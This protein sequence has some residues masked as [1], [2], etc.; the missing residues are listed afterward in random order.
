[1]ERTLALR[2]TLLVISLFLIPT[3]C[4]SQDKHPEL[5]LLEQRETPVLTVQS[6]GAEGNE[7][8]FENGYVVK[9]GR[10]YHL[11][12]AEMVGRPFVVKMK[13][14][15][16]ASTDRL[17]WR[18]VS[19]LYSSSAEYTGQDPRAALWGPTPIYDEKEGRWN[20]FYT[21]Y[22]SAPDT[23]DM[24]R[25]NYDGKIWRAVSQERGLGGIDGPYKDVGIVLQPGP[26]SE[27]WEGGQGTDSFFPYQ[28]GGKWYSFYGSCNTKR[29]GNNIV[30]PWLVGLVSA[31]RLAGPWKRLP[32]NPVPISTK[33]IEA[34]IVTQLKDGTYVAVYDSEVS[35]AVGYTFSSDGVRWF[36]GKTLVVQPKGKGRWAY[37]VRTPLGLIPESDGTLTLFYTGF[38]HVPSQ[39]KNAW[40]SDKANPGDSAVGLVIVKLGSPR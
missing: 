20:L 22:R 12:I 37:H 11:F 21:A 38:Q 36:P 28:A 24:W 14:G 39:P 17:H 19:T 30:G 23:P 29:D 25:A 3:F 13:L 40:E 34:P 7:F 32:E 33:F 6:P 2:L 18:R 16:W 10:T 15:H 1:M 4:I 26:E 5:V 27:P 35:N 9:V 8:G 31:P